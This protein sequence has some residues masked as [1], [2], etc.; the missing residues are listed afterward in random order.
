MA[1][2]NLTDRLSR[3]FKNLV[4]QGKLTE[5]NM[6]DMIQEVR[7]A[8]IEADVH[9]DVVSSFITNIETKALGTEVMKSLKPSEQ[10][11]KIV[12][13]ELIEILGTTQESLD[14]TQKPTIVMMVGLQGSGKTTASGKIAK[15]LKEKEGKKVL[16][17]AAD[18]QRLAAVDQLSILAEMVQVDIYA[19][20]NSTPLA[21]VEAGVKKAKAEAY[22][23]V[24]ID[25]AGR[26][27]IDNVLMDE[28]TQIQ[29]AVH[30]HEILLT[31]DAMV[32][33]DIVNVAKAFKEQ[34][35]LTGLVVTKYDGDSRGGGILSVRTI[36]KVPVKFV[37]VGEKMEDLEL[38][39][40]D[41]V[42]SRLLGMG[43][44][45]TLIEQAQAKIDQDKAELAAKRLMEG[46]FTMD[47]LLTSLQQM[48][49]LGSFSGI[50]KLMPGM[51]QLS[52]QIDEAKSENTLKVTQAIIQ[53]MTKAERENPK[54][55]M[56]GRKRRIANGAGVSMNDVNKLLNQ[57]SKMKD[58]MRL[59]SRF[60]K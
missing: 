59:L 50:L 32:G 18:L 23:A 44:I 3:S 10:V 21:V 13:E 46:T 24:L 26:L 36:T 41:R 54:I 11:V 58:Q 5:K 9:P 15:Y 31:V 37:G 19:D 25:T 40:P 38:F 39:Y 4:G 28:L 48:S 53:S 29:Q 51:S 17:I 22:D 47:D 27:H 12:N 49:K 1:F 60:M 45:L 8:L 16:L 42:A 6:R 33:Q 20:K 43:D 7:F 14:L 57:Y 34:V 30:P 55:I 2:E 35:N 56:S 52:S